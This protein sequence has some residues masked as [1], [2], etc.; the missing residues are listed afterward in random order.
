[1]VNRS[2]NKEDTIT[3]VNDEN[4]KT[5]EVIGLSLDPQI[6]ARQMYAA[7]R[8]YSKKETDLLILPIDKKSSEDW[9]AINNRL[10]KASTWDFRI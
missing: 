3:K 6:F 7:F 4:I 2:F 1:M 8:E 9:D 5:A 10:K